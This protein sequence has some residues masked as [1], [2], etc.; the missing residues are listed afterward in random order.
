MANPASGPQPDARRVRR[1]RFFRIAAGA[2][3][4]VVGLNLAKNFWLS[5][6]PGWQGPVSD[7]FDGKEFF[8]PG[9]PGGKSFWEVMRWRFGGGRAEW[10]E[11]AGGLVKPALPAAL[12]EGEC[13]ATFIGHATA[14]LQFHDL[15]VLT[16]PQWS[17]RCS[18]VTFAGP[19]RIRP[20]G[21]AWEDLPPV[22]L[23]LLS[24]NHYDHLDLPTLRRLDER[25]QPTIITGLGNRAFLA[26]H[27]L[28]RVVEL[29]WWQ[30]HETNGAR[31]HFTPANHWSHRGGFGLNTTLWGGF[32]LQ[33]GKRSICFAGDTGY[34]PHFAQVRER[35]GAPDLALLPIGAYEPEWFMRPVH[36]N[37]EDA[38]RAHRDLGARQSMGIHFGTWQLTNEAEDAPPA[39]LARER[40]KAGLAETAFHAPAFG[41]TLRL[42]T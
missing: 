27:G 40:A 10:P 12:R 20:P 25:F 24:H 35:I 38:V 2:V 41:E 16:D 21:L 3:A 30:A 37:P 31:I 11:S 5:A 23:V 19:R 6:G 42:A 17:E 15:N 9:G 8:N 1:R 22:Q 26:R 34:G 32:V 33:A 18:P 4:S 39:A 36:M 7:H 14:L 28:K 29:D 13:A